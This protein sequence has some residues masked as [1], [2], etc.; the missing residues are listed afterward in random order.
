M[1]LESKNHSWNDNHLLSY[2]LDLRNIKWHSTESLDYVIRQAVMGALLVVEETE[3]TF[4][5]MMA[6]V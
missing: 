3:S 1:N 6:V 5:L 4:F 2:R